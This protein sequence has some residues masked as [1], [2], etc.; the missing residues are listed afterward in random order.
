ME[1]VFNKYNLPTSAS[2]KE[3]QYPYLEYEQQSLMIILWNY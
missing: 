1:N 2:C 3:E